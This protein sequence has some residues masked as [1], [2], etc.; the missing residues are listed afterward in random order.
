MTPVEFPQAN[1]HYTPPHGMTEGQVATV[2][3]WAG[4][5]A[6]GPCEGAP[7]I[8]I[9]W[10]PTQEEL[11]NIVSGAPIYLSIMGASLPPHML[12]TTFEDAIAT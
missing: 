3:A 1:T 5:V 10:R 8:V 4:E 9:A 7:V 6:R 2:H 11:V 12:S